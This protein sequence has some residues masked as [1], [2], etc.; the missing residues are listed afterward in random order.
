MEM[1][2]CLLK[3]AESKEVGGTA[4]YESRRQRHL[5]ANKGTTRLVGRVPWRQRLRDRVPL[6][7]HGRPRPMTCT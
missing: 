6:S 5:E 4:M 1:T 3:W 7:A 2:T